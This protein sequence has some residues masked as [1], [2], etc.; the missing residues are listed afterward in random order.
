[1]TRTTEISQAG[2]PIKYIYTCCD[3]H[4]SHDSL[5]IRLK[6]E[7]VGR[8]Q[9]EILQTEQRIKAI[10]Q[11]C[12]FSLDNGC[13]GRLPSPDRQVDDL[14]HFFTVLL[15]ERF[16]NDDDRWALGQHVLDVQRVFHDR[17]YLVCTPPTVAQKEIIAFVASPYIESL[18]EDVH[19]YSDIVPLLV[20]TLSGC[21]EVLWRHWLQQNGLPNSPSGESVSCSDRIS[22]SAQCMSHLSTIMQGKMD[23]SSALLQNGGGIPN[24]DRQREVV[25][26]AVKDAFEAKFGLP[27]DR[28]ESFYVE[29]ALDKLVRGETVAK[30]ISNA[31][32]IPQ[33]FAFPQLMRSKR[34]EIR[35]DGLVWQR[36]IEGVV[37]TAN[38]ERMLK[39]YG[40]K[41]FPKSRED[42]P[43]A[44]ADPSGEVMR[45]KNTL[46]RE[47][48]GEPYPN[49]TPEEQLYCAI[50]DN[51]PKEA[52]EIIKRFRLN[53]NAPLSGTDT[54]LYLA[55]VRQKVEVEKALIALGADVRQAPSN[56]GS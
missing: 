55:R 15:T 41:R 43:E 32:F 27:A 39:K 36:L 30:A 35:D 28:F 22:Q 38:E 24:L 44:A 48:D 40:L 13:S 4:C 1:M 56:G 8:T 54:P 45:D 49:M 11:Q 12:G 9:E 50:L 37:P 51:D 19:V 14:A 7:Q 47:I 31:Y 5:H 42:L 21:G 20:Y 33:D 10:A 46:I 17:A 3:L 29:V 18:L 53:V 6:S 52:V 16:I 26:A 34:L 25:V 23:L 2:S